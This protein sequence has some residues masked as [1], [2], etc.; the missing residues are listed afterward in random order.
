MNVRPTLDDGLSIQMHRCTDDYTA[1]VD[2]PVNHA[3]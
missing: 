3:N 1:G 2:D